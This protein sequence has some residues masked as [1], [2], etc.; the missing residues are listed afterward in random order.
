[1]SDQ[2]SDKMII[3]A[4]GFGAAMTAR[5]SIE[6]AKKVLLD[7]EAISPWG[8][9]FEVSGCTKETGDMPIAADLSDFEEVVMRALQSFNDVRYY[10]RG[11]PDN[12]DLTPNSFSPYGFCETF[13][14][15]PS[16]IVY[17]NSIAVTI[18]SAYVRDMASLSNAIYL[19]EV[20]LYQRGQFNEAWAHRDI[21][22]RL[23]DYFIDSCAPSRAIVY[24]QSQGNRISK[25]NN[26][27][28]LGWLNYTMDPKVGEMFTATGKAVPY[29][30]G[31]LLKLGDD[32]S[33]LSDPKIDAELVEIGEMLWSAGVRA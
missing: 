22:Y 15:A 17:K 31:V 16:S 14:N 33:V 9:P 5:Q 25:R 27:Y 8:R 19:I 13:S 26:S 12:A 2:R 28:M 30:G 24:A 7:L 6:N 18:N 10:N 29:H 11:D 3:R 23:F 32:V 4:S 20:P 21:L 1:M